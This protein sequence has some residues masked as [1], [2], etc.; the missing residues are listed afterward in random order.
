MAKE[1][2]FGWVLRLFGFGFLALFGLGFFSGC[3]RV[4]ESG[5]AGVQF[6]FGKIS[7]QPLSVGWHF[8]VPGITFI[9]IWDVK[10]L[11]SCPRFASIW[12]M[13]SAARPP[14]PPMGGNS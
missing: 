8:F 13:P 3:A 4:V 5:Q 7:E 11:I 6:D 12:Q 14:P 9:E 1:Q 2:N 10:T